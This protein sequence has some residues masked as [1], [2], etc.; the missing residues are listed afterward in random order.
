[1]IIKYDEDVTA[2]EATKAVSRLGM[3]S[4]TFDE[5]DAHRKADLIGSEASMILARPGNDLSK[6]LNCRL[7]EAHFD[8]Q[9]SQSFNLS[10]EGESA[11]A[12]RH[13]AQ[14]S[15]I[16]ARARLVRRYVVVPGSSAFHKEAR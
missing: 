1:V 13:I 7:A 2:L 14:S 3:R 11:E 4:V 12:R 10:M 6:E 9:Y 16:W 8:A 15:L 5:L